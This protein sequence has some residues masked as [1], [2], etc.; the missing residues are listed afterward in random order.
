M[1]MHRFSTVYDIGCG[2]GFKLIKYLGHYETVGFD[3]EP[4]VSFLAG[5]EYPLR[6]VA[7]GRPNG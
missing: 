2:S 5:A 7:R 3:V 6:R 1:E 4:T